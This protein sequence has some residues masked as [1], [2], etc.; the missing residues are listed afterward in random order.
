MIE[1]AGQIVAHSAWRHLRLLS[2]DRWIDAAGIG[3]VT[4]HSDWR[5]QGLASRTV[6]EC[7]RRAGDAGAAVAL[8]FSES[9]PLYK[10]LGFVPAGRERLT[11]LEPNGVAPEATGMRVGTVADASALLDLMNRHSLRV[12]RSE[13]DFERLLSIPQAHLWVLEERG[14]PTAYC[15]EGKGRDLRG[16]VHEWSGSREAVGTLLGALASRSQNPLFVLSPEPE[17]PPIEG[18][19]RIGALAQLRILRPH[20]LGLQGACTLMLQ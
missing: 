12:F 4:T 10:R 19:H 17:P 11:R 7:A 16:V 3:L 20:C 6:E 13:H 15:V 9:R 8:L 5:G 2:C 1:D 14:A 18:P